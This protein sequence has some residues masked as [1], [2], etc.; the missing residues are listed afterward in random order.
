MEEP[1]SR[2]LSHPTW[3]D[4]HAFHVLL[5]QGQ[6]GEKEAPRT[7]DRNAPAK[8]TGERSSRA[9]T[10]AGITN[11]DQL[12][13]INSNSVRFDVEPCACVVLARAKFLAKGAN[14][15]ESRGE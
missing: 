3:W 13:A 11:E 5:H 6:L 9:N 14:P 1:Q 15:E 7:R 2:S 12:R 4:Q 8:T 10:A